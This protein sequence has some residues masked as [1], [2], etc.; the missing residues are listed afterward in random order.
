MTNDELATLMQDR[1][2]RLDEKVAQIN[3]YVR[4]HETTIQVLS[5][6]VARH[7]KNWD[8]VWKYV[9]AAILV[10]VLAAVLRGI[11]LV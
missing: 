8:R 4:K 2:T 7:S 1:F 9:I 3:G 10:A 11:G 6:T 5:V